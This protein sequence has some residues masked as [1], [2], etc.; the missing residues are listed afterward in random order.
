MAQL[1][2]VKFG[3]PIL[4]KV[5]EPIKTVTPDLVALTEDMLETMHKASGVGLAANQV[6]M[7]L[8]IAVI[9]FR[10]TVLRMFNPR[11]LERSGEPQIYSEGCLSVPGVDGDVK[12][13]GE[14]RAQ[15]LDEN[16]QQH[17]RVFSGHLARIV[18]HEVD[19]LNGI[20]IVNHFST[21]ARTLHRK[22]LDRLKDE[23]TAGRR[24]HGR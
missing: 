12:R 23:S 17:E 10:E 6:G 21:A 9:G 14:V 18:Q 20:V 1:K 3:D 15:W 7:D 4:R 16:N 2:I 5:V 19:H 22:T 8:S 11:I 24:V 13:A